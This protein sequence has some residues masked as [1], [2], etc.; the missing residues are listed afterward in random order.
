MEKREKIQDPWATP[1]ADRRPQ[2][3]KNVILTRVEVALL[4]I[5]ELFYEHYY[6]QHQSNEHPSILYFSWNQLRQWE[7]AAII[8][9]HFISSLLILL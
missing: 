9:V 5:N 4:V 7:A 3:E 8:N 6:F 1:R 2:Q